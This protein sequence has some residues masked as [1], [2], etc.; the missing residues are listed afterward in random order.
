MGAGP[1]ASRSPV[2]GREGRKNRLPSL[3][4]T[5]TWLPRRAAGPRTK[6]PREGRRP[7]KNP[8]HEGQFTAEKIRKREKERKANEMEGER[9]YHRPLHEAPG[10]EERDVP[11]RGG[12]TG[13]RVEARDHCDRR[14]QCHRGG[15]Q[16][17]EE[18]RT[19]PQYKRGHKKSFWDAVTSLT[20]A[21]T[22]LNRRAMHLSETGTTTASQPS[23]EKK[24]EEETRRRLREETDCLQEERRRIKEEIGALRA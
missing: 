1:E 24:R 15:R 20:A 22:V 18:A 16:D 14:R 13:T 7:A 3:P 8:S 6:R 21:L 17:V 2:A 4:A 19:L 11:G 5:M 10:Q 23:T 12:R 9:L